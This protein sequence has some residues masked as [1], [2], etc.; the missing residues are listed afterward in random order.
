MLVSQNAILD[1]ADALNHP[2]FAICPDDICWWEPYGRLW[3]VNH[4]ARLQLAAAM[5]AAKARQALTQSEQDGL[6]GSLFNAEQI[7]LVDK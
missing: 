3:V 7:A 2:A 1:S 5:S 4:G 6:L